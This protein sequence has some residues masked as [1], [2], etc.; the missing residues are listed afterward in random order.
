LPE[1]QFFTIAQGTNHPR[2]DNSTPQGRAA[3]RRIELV[4][5]PD[6]F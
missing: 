1:A 4:V 3:N 5:Y 2:A 6:T